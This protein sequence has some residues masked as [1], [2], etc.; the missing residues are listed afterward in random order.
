M[1]IGKEMMEEV[2][3]AH[4]R[5]AANLELQREQQTCFEKRKQEKRKL[6]AEMNAAKAAKVLVTEE[7]RAKTTQLDSEIFRL[8]QELKK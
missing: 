1:Q 6:T 2:D 4:K 7:L 5:Y 8:E 3:K